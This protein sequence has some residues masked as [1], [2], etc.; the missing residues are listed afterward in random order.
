[1]KVIK[2]I[3]SKLYS[4]LN[5]KQE[6]TE[7]ETAG[8]NGFSDVDIIIK[9]KDVEIGKLRTISFCKTSGTKTTC[10]D[11]DGVSYEIP[12]PRPR[13]E[14]IAGSFMFQSFDSELLQKTIYKPLD[15]IMTCADEFGNVKEMEIREIEILDVNISKIV[16]MWSYTFIAK[17]IIDWHL[18]GE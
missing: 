1:M 17:E 13:K 4:F 10:P 5:K 15:V 11:L 7:S 12:G 9:H 2:K 3:L 16:V 14:A 8:Y 18:K 6:V